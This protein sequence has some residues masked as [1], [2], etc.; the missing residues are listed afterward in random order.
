MILGQEQITL[1]TYGVQDRDEDTG[2]AIIATPT[3]APVFASVQP[4][5]GKDRQTLPEGQREKD[6]HRLYTE[7]AMKPA[8]Q[9]TLA[10]CDRVVIDGDEF[11]VMT[12][13]RE[14]AIIKHYKVLVVKT[15]EADPNA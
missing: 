13:K 9:Y 8:S 3:S 11:Q 15:Q 10:N 12:A 5:S 6:G 4:L 14:R 2:A 7:T 1:K